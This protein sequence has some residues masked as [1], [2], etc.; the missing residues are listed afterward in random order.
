M[1]RPRV[2]IVGTGIA[3]LGAAH[4]LAPHADLV[5]FEADDRLGG[6]TNTRDVLEPGGTRPVDTGFIVHNRSTYPRLLALF[7][8]LGVSTQ[9]ASMAMSICCQQC[10]LQYASERPWSIV[11]GMVRNPSLLKLLVE[12]WRFR[13]Q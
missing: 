5:L 3:G 12:I 1:S 13:R 9:P 7:A 6:H 2:A 10:G 4:L 11:R 8:E